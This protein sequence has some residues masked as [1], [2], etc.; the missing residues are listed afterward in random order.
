MS[1]CEFC[2]GSDNGLSAM[3]T[4]P[5]MSG[6][7][8]RGHRPGC[9]IGKLGEKIGEPMELFGTMVDPMS[10]TEIEMRSVTTFDGPDSHRMEHYMTM[11]GLPEM[12]VMELVYT[13][14]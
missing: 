14:R 6:K 5:P 3:F 11:R 7:V 9:P 2:G 8:Y 4:Y 13:R 12:K 1:Y 10:G